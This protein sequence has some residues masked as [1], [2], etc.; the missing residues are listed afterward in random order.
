[1]SLRQRAK[2]RFGAV[3]AK[4]LTVDGK[5]VKGITTGT[6]NVDPGSIT[7]ATV[8]TVAVTITGVVAGDIVVMEPPANLAAQ[9]VYVGCRVSANTVTVILANIGATVNDSVCTWTYKHIPSA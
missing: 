2:A 4:S 5:T 6:V 8:G 3:I 9:L 1:M 7:A